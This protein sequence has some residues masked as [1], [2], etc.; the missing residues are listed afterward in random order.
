[1]ARVNSICCADRQM[2]IGFKVGALQADD[3]LTVVQDVSTKTDELDHYTLK[4]GDQTDMKN[5]DFILT[6]DGLVEY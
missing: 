5:S 4:L 1:M 6:E 3:R 2:L